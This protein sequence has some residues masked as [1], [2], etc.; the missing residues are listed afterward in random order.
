MT[1]DGLHQ[2]WLV[3][4][5]D[6]AERSGTGYRRA[7]QWP[8]AGTAA[9][10]LVQ[11]RNLIVNASIGWQRVVERYIVVGEVAV[12]AADSALHSWTELPSGSVQIGCLKDH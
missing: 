12:P 9:A 10:L 5:F 4:L 3:P 1:L 7:E 2:Q 6:S 8:A 11:S